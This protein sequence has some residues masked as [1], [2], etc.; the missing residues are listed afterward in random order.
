MSE[1]IGLIYGVYDAK[2]EGFVPGGM[3]LHNCMLPHGPD[4]DTYEGASNADVKPHKLENTFAF[5]FD[6][7]FPQ[8]LTSYA[9]DLET[10]Q[11]DY[12]GCWQG[13]VRKFDGNQ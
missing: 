6:T 5:M 1:F 8:H 12:S 10:L 4:N 3:S 7:R 9:A 11:S 2:L 13:L